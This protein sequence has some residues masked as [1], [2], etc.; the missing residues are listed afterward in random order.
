MEEL[1]VVARFVAE[2]AQDVLPVFEQ[3]VPGDPRPRAA[4][5]A[6][7]EFVNGARRTKL[8]R[9]TSL[10]AHRA[11]KDAGTEVARLA[12]RSAG[13]AASAAYLH[14][15]S[16]ATQVGH[17]LRA[18]ASVARIAELDAGGDP[19]VGD[20]MIEQA[21]QRAT[22]VLI[23]VLSRYPPAPT[24]KNRVAQLMSNLDSSLRASG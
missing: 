24:A 11:A 17:I 9:V 2:S 19:A 23:S 18:A 22:P 20:M 16:R 3:A 7:W 5:D 15:I 14:P 8:Q 1:R 6:A 4:V 10:D 12:A 13:D 21:R